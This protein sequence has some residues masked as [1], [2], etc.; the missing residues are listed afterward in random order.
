MKLLL[1]TIFLTFSFASFAGVNCETM[2]ID[3]DTAAA[4]ISSEY[5]ADRIEQSCN[6]SLVYG[7]ERDVFELENI[8]AQVVDK[9]D[10]VVG[11]LTGNSD[12]TIVKVTAEVNGGQEC[13]T[14]QVGKD[15][16]GNPASLHSAT[17]VACSR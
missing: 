10:R 1:T 2:W 7:S 15:R 8:R 12:Y 9:R 16:H 14:L 6:Y 3:R 13:F 5:I 17:T 11:I 4:D